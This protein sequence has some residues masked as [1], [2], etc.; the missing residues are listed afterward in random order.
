MR[1]FSDDL[2]FHIK[3]HNEL[4]WIFYTICSITFFF[5]NS[6]RFFPDDLLLLS[7]TAMLIWPTIKQTNKHAALRRDSGYVYLTK[8]FRSKESS[9]SPLFALRCRNAEFA[10]GCKEIA[11]YVHQGRIWGGGVFLTH[12][13]LSLEK[14]IREIRWSSWWNSDRF[15]S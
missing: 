9:I 7:N 11:S 12:L 2:F 14:E 4:N 8:F 13:F 1:F 15:C 10:N 3:H 6:M 5:P